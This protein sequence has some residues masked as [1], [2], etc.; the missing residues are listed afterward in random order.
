M[1]KDQASKARHEAG[2][3][4]LYYTEWNISSNPRDPLHDEPFSAA[5]I[6]RI[7]MEARGL[8]QGYSY[9]TFSDI[10]S[11]NYFPSVPFQ[12]GF[13]LL[14]LHGIPKP[15][16]RAF[17]LLHALGTQLLEV[18]GTHATV[19]AWVVRKDKTATIITTNLAMRR[20]S[21]QT[22]LLNVRLSNAG[23]P[24]RAWIE[25]IDEDHANPRRL[26]EAMGKPEY[27]TP[28]EVKQLET[29]STLRQEAQP[30]DGDGGDVNLAVAL[31]PQSVAAI[32]NRSDRLQRMD[33]HF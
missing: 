20:N 25:R 26:W 10:F 12:G 24:R 33:L 15:A 1:M 7:V 31:P 23:V 13:G 11:E 21:I 17:Q 4:P 9:W 30:W 19:D 27:L 32:T 22:E 29:A 14:N 16:Y 3:L 2:D 18:N 28:L 6:T 5:F 8:V